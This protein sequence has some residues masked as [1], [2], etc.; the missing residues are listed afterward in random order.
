MSTRKLAKFRDEEVQ[1]FENVSQARIAILRRVSQRM[2]DEKDWYPWD[3]KEEIR[4]L[5]AQVV[6]TKNFVFNEN[7]FAN[8]LNYITSIVTDLPTQ[9][10]KP[11]TQLDNLFKIFS[12]RSCKELLKSFIDITNNLIVYQKPNT[13]NSLES[14]LYNA[15]HNALKTFSNTVEKDKNNWTDEELLRGIIFV[16][17]CKMCEDNFD[18]KLYDYLL[19]NNFSNFHYFSNIDTEKRN[20]LIK[21]VET[22]YGGYSGNYDWRIE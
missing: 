7:D 6:N 11:D 18:S 1:S 21:Y 10:T 22:L 2:S 9:K 12:E 15:F 19:D 8:L 4:N 20:D 3:H 13:Y 16:T 17:L 14:N 5:Y